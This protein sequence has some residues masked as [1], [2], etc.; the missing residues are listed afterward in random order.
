MIVKL[1]LN[2]MY[3]NFCLTYII[4]KSS[5]QTTPECSCHCCGRS[6]V[7]SYKVL[8]PGGDM[9]KCKVLIMLI[10]VDSRENDWR[11]QLLR[12]C[13]MW[14]RMATAIQWIF[15][16]GNLECVRALCVS[17]YVKK[18]VFACMCVPQNPYSFIS[19]VK[20][21]TYSTSLLAMW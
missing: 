13:G 18:C 17:V 10:R 12:G 2:I 5:S 14:S 20:V 19:C 4:C 9:H 6:P 11:W 3:N 21:F 15:L 1:W 16:S 7:D 8:P